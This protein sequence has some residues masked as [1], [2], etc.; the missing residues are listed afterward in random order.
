ML[1]LLLACLAAP[2]AP[3][4]PAPSSPAPATAD[5]VV[6][7]ARMAARAGQEPAPG[8]G[9]M[10]GWPPRR[11]RS[12]SGRYEVQV[13]EAR[14]LRLGGRTLDEPVDP[15]VRF[16]AD[17]AWLYFA[18][19]AGLGETELWRIAL[20]DGSPEPVVQWP[21]SADRP[22]PS[23]DGRWLAFVSGRTGIAA[24]WRVPLDG[25]LPVPLERGEQLTNHE[26]RR[27]PGQPPPGFLPPPTSEGPDWE[28]STLRWTAGGRAHA[29]AVAP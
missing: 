24:L 17:E 13:D 9:P 1:P 2:P 5:E 22:S 6:S 18:R 28:G 14:R 23:P 29:L 11:T 20:P 12:P 3:S 7:P 8:S 15:R 25:P 21:G 10:D 27:A 19:D 4:S 26:T 16:S